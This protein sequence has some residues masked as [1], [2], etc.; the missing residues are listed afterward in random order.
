MTSHA[1]I[2]INGNDNFTLAN[3]VTSGSGRVSD[4]YIIEN[5]DISAENGHGIC[6][7]N[8]TAYFVIRNCYVHDG[9]VNGYYGI[10]FDN[11][12]NGIVKNNI[13]ENNYYGMYLHRNY[14][15]NN[16]IISNN[17]VENN[18]DGIYMGD[19]VDSNLIENNIVDHNSGNG[20]HLDSW[21]SNNIIEN[22]TVNYNSGNGI[23]LDRWPS[24]NIIENN[25][26]NYNSG[27]GIFL[28]F[29]SSNNLIKNN[30]VYHNSGNGINFRFTS[31]NDMI[32][33]NDVDSNY[34]GIHLE[35]ASNDTVTNNTVHNNHNGINIGNYANNVIVGNNIVDHNSENGINIGNY[36]NNVIV[37]NN[38]VYHNSANGIYINL[39]SQNNLI[40]NNVVDSNY[41][42]IYLGWHADTN[43][44]FHNNFINNVIQAYDDLGSN[45][46]DNGYPSG[47]NY[48]S[49]YAGSD[50]NRDGIGD[51]PYYISGGGGQ[52]HYPLMCPWPNTATLRLE[53]LYKIS[54]A[55][56]FQFYDGSV[57]GVEF[58]KYDNITYQD[59]SLIESITPPQSVVENDNI[60]HPRAAE[61]YSWGTVQIAKLIL[62]DSDGNVILTLATFTVYQSDLRTRYMAI[63]R[64]WSGD[65]GL[66]PAFRS[67][68]LDILKQ[69][70]S[71]PISGGPIHIY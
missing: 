61:K 47:G 57:L 53:N 56:N 8:A 69:W 50:N 21:L 30:I 23:Q 60:P 38:I 45:Y 46:W 49:D 40:E 44:I 54:L 12:T 14:Y 28:D 19:G 25:T 20:I 9:Q 42:P 43:Q 36:A 32:E 67:E 5:W 51:T 71:A 59:F 26:V 7:S 31:N 65:P 13:V 70:S 11:S 64:A 2:Y 29:S 62:A 63:L 15:L 18:H 6:V 16:N 4:P 55:V 68:I 27:N 48:W 39:F 37:R 22:N 58:Y 3:G 33:N 34:E 52:D 24:N 17:I 1:Q 35:S 10:F 41:D 66:Q